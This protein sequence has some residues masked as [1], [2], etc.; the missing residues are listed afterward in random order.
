MNKNESVLIKEI[1]IELFDCYKDGPEYVKWILENRYDKITD[2]LWKD[3]VKITKINGF[4][5]SVHFGKEDGR[6]ELTYCNN[7]GEVFH[8]SLTY[9][10]TGK[11]IIGV[12]KCANESCN[13]LFCNSEFYEQ[14]LF[15]K[16]I[17]K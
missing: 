8:H 11:K 12:T 2:K 6:S 7:C 13:I 14:Y 5:H 16:G 17:T 4:R 10:E 9:K 1:F 3:Y 15:I